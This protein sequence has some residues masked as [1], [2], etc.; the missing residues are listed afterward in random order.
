MPVPYIIP[1]YKDKRQLDLCT[2]AI[3]KQDEPT[4]PWIHDNSTSNLYYTKAENLGLKYAL[5]K[6]YEFAI[7]GTQDVYLRPTAVSG[8]VQFMR[9]HPRCAICGPRQVL[10]SD[11]DFV[12]HA[13]CTIAY[14]AGQ[15]I[16]G[17]KSAGA[18]A[19]S[20]TVPW[21]NGACMFARMEAIV[22]IGLMDENMLM[23]GSDSD[24]CYTAR[25]RNWEVWYC[26]DGECIHEVGVSARGGS[27]ELIKIFQADM[28]YWR[29]KWVGS[30]LFA[31]LAMEFNFTNMKDAPFPAGR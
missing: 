18:G 9:E 31:K 7:V 27:P 20:R 6:G 22:E 13:G 30:R 12:I 4:E 23:L 28:L 3:A 10:A 25:A 17:K 2:A 15:H 14:P 1:F 8:M 11:E 19:A 16:S 29:D 26:A 5:S 21:V 24:W